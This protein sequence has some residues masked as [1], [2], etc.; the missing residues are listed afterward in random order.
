MNL[1][2]S[3]EGWSRAKLFHKWGQDVNTC[4]YYIEYF[5]EPGDVVLDPFVGGGTTIVAAQ[6]VGREAIGFDIDP[7]AIETTRR[8]VEEAWVPVPMPLFEA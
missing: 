2:E 3:G 5:S 8:R 6:L 4:R 7:A 1:F